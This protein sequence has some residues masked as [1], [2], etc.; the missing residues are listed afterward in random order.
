MDRCTFINLLKMEIRY[1][2][3]ELFYIIPVAPVYINAKV[4]GLIPME[5]KN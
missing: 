3:Q 4:I 5:S 1:M 2:I